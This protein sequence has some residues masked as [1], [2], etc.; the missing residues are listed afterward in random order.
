MRLNNFA[1]VDPFHK[2]RGIGGLP[3][4]RKQGLSIKVSLAISENLEVLLSNDLK[5]KSDEGYYLKYFASLAGSRII[6]PKRYYPKK[7]FLQFHLDNIF[8]G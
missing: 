5:K 2:E 8:K 7:E 1:S 3:G 4:G 6:P